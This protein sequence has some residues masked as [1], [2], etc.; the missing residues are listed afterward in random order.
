MKI[1]IFG[2]GGV[3]GY[4]GGRLAASGEEVTFLARG[5]HLAAMQQGGLRI[6]SPLGDA[7]IARVQATDRPQAVGPVDVILLTT[8][9]YDTDAAA[10]TLAPMIGPGTA[11][12]T[13]QNGIDAVEMVARHV[14]RP[15]VVG[16]VA[17]VA[18]VIDAP[19]VIRH[20]A[21]DTLMTGSK[22]NDA[23]GAPLRALMMG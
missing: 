20:T 4:F 17:Y 22:G 2:S 11:V 1:A 23:T 13:L 14:G 9:M 8:K 12:I 16:G 3:G 21:L 5:A 18:A 15:H 6:T 10:E 19:G 7:H